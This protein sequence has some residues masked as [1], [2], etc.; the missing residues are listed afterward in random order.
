MIA[1]FTIY[2]IIKRALTL[3]NERIQM[4]VFEDKKEKALTLMEN[5]KMWRSNYAPPLLKMLWRLGAKVP[6]PPFAPFWLNTVIFSIVFIPL[7]GIFM[8]FSTW[9]DE[10][11]S[12]LTM[13]LNSLSA[14]LIYGACMALFHFWRMRA[15][16]LPDWKSL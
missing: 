7:W 3:L 14:G 1:I 9:Q 8:W 4:M 13:T 16:D 12:V 2:H 5:K 11:V 15:K 10:P 6:P